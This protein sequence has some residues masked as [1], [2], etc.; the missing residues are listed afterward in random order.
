LPQWILEKVRV[1]Q[2][3]SELVKG[4]ARGARNVTTTSVVGSL[5]ARYP[6]QEWDSICWPLIV[7]FNAQNNRPPLGERE[8]RTIFESIAR[9]QARSEPRS[10]LTWPLCRITTPP[11]GTGKAR[12]RLRGLR[13]SAARTRF[14][15]SPS[16]A[17]LRIIAG[18]SRVRFACFP[19]TSP[20]FAGPKARE[21]RFERR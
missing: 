2:P 21:A 10:P 17:F 14:F 11:D 12:S 7:G 3:L 15:F 18:S 5:L 1:R 9:R 6:P 16:L 20:A 19:V 4:S 8:L 13:F